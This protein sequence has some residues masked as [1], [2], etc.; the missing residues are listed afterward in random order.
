MT[1]VVQPV[2]DGYLADPFVFKHLDT[3]YVV[4]T[5]PVDGEFLTPKKPSQWAFP[6]LKS[7][8]LK[9]WEWQGGAL[10]VPEWAQHGDF[11][12]PEVGFWN[13]LFY[14][15]YSVALEGLKHILRVAT[16]TS[17]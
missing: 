17:P 9:N 3:F 10:Q 2:Y 16:S 13:G 5:G 14:L 7:H 12:A 15:Y 8:D 4:G 6:L 11:W 1:P